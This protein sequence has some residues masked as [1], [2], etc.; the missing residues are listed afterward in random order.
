MQDN[1]KNSN[2][3]NTIIVIVFSLLIS[4]EFQLCVANMHDTAFNEIL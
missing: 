2:I 3:K 1:N 4:T